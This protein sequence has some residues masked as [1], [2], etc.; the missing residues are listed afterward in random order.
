MAE[1]GAGAGVARAGG[2]SA[3]AEGIARTT[4]ALGIVF[5]LAGVVLRGI[6]AGHWP[7]ANMF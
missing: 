1:A 2:A 6:A 5:L 4:T 3:R 7:T